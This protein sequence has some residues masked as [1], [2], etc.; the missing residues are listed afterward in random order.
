MVAKLKEKD[1]NIQQIPFRIHRNDYI[2]LKKILIEDDMK[3]QTFVS[4][5]IEAYMRG[6]A[7]IMMCVKDWKEL[8]IIPKEHRSKYTLS[9]RERQK[10]LDELE[11]APAIE[12]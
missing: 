8:S 9:S 3:F 5:C 2:L 10:I 7:N 4:S 1:R 6:D 12:K 11:E